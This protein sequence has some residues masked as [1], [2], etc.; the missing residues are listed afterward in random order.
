MP[1]NKKGQYRKLTAQEALKTMLSNFGD[2]LIK[3]MDGSQS[4]K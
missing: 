1:R 4:N 2:K 3:D